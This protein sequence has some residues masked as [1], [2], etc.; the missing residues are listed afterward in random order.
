MARVLKRSHSF[1]CTPCIHPLLEWT[2]PAFAGTHLP[3]PEGWKDELALSGWLVTWVTEVHR[4]LTLGFW[5]VERS[6]CI[7]R[8]WYA[9]TSGLSRMTLSVRIPPSEKCFGLALSFWP[10]NLISSS[11][12]PTAQNLYFSEFEQAVYNILHEQ[13]FSIWSQT[14]TCT[15][16]LRDSLKTECLPGIVDGR[17][18]KHCS[19]QCQKH[20]N[21]FI[22]HT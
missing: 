18:I 5:L 17:G 13:A 20:H 14:H 9:G 2:I 8:A 10:Q 22:H 7:H 3:T 1:T 19:K 11:L 6:I 16:F 12:C 21:H 15:L 4:H